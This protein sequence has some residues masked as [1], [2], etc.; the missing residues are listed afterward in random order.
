MVW[1][2]G[3][4]VSPYRPRLRV[5]GV[6]AVLFDYPVFPGGGVGRPVFLTADGAGLAI[7]PPVGVRRRL[8]GDGG[9]SH[10]ASSV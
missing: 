6:G 10:L 7:L 4:L 2:C 3:F 9:V 8:A 1:S 5:A